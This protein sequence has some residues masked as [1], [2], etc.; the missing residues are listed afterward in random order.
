MGVPLPQGVEGGLGAVG[1]V[2]FAQDVADV[3]AHGALA[4]HEAVGN[5]LVGQDTR[6]SLDRVKASLAHEIVL[7]AEQQT[8]VDA[9]FKKF[10][11][12]PHAPPSAKMVQEEIGDALMLA[13]IDLERLVQVSPD[14]LFARDDY[15]KMVSATKGMLQSSGEITVADVRDHFQTSRKY[16]LAFLEHLDAIGVTVRMGD[17]RKLKG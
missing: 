1:Q 9:L 17:V 13:L 8:Q 10:A 11:A 16:A 12:A 5:F 4:D 15:E 7:T 3:G 6:I 2:Q 14:V